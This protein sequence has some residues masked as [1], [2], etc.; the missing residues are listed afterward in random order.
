MLL[1]AVED[2]PARRAFDPFAGVRQP[3]HDYSGADLRC[4]S[5]DQSV[6]GVNRASPDWGTA[7]PAMRH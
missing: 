5:V 7:L 4:L 1:Y 2:P 6:R 3:A